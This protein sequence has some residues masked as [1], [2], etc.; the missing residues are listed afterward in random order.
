[1]KILLTIEDIS[2]FGGAERVVVNLANALS[3]Q[4]YEVE[5]LSFYQRHPKFFPILKRMR[6]WFY[7]ILVFTLMGRRG[8][9]PATL[10][11]CC[12]VA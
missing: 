4:G 8:I 1:M 3:E 9:L 12:L 10:T 7:T 5:V 11:E 2:I 6:F